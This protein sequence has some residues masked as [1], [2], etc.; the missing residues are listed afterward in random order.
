MTSALLLSIPE[1]AHSLG[2]GRSKLYQLIKEREIVPVRIGSRTLV[3]AP[4]LTAFVRKAIERAE[5]RDA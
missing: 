4:V 2:I 1:A 5:V 3:P